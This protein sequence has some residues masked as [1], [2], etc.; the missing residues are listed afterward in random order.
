[1]L[2]QERLHGRAECGHVLRQQLASRSSPCRMQDGP[3]SWFVAG[4]SRMRSGR[5]CS[6]RKRLR[7]DGT[8]CIGFEAL[9]PA[10]RQHWSRPGQP[11]RQGVHL[12][13][14]GHV[15]V[16]AVTRAENNALDSLARQQV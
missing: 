1:M 12:Y 10:Y 14:S 9:L 3:H 15:I 16:C 7:M 5:A 4:I 2:P 6:A 11:S 8:C 13:D